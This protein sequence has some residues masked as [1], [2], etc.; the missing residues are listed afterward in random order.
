M[1]KKEVEALEFQ[2]KWLEFEMDLVFKK[3]KE[4]W[5]KYR[6]LNEVKNFVDFEDKKI[7]DVG[8]GGPS[9]VLHLLKG[10]RYGVDP[11][12]DELQEIYELNRNI[13][14][15]KAYGENL[16]FIDKNFDIVICSNALDHMENH[17]EA[18][19]EIDRILKPNGI[20]I[21]T[22]D[23]FKEKFKRDKK[24]PHTF[25][26]KDVLKLF[27][28]FKI[29]FKK[30]SSVNASFFKFLNGENVESID[31]DDEYFFN[32]SGIKTSDVMIG[33][34]VIVAEKN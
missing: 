3:L 9:S 18:F 31:A 33:E 34:I 24:H 1:N 19:K 30:K 11:I 22:V 2:K 7:V 27:K 8:C 5:I 4:Y 25:V 23:I 6:F 21:L 15:I 17:I 20:F 28:D 29:L 26:E 13:Q 32:E 10:E 14:W 12:I 16:P